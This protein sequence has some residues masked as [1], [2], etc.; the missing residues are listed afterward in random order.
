[1]NKVFK[2][3]SRTKYCESGSAAV[4]FAFI[5]LLL[6]A[7]TVG[8]VEFGRAFWLYNKLSNAIEKTSRKNLVKSIDDAQIAKEIKKDFPT[9]EVGTVW[10]EPP[11]V[12]VTLGPNF[13]TVKAVIA[14][15]PVIPVLMGE[16]IDITLTRRFWKVP[17]AT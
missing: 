2:S 16:N 4:E 5:G 7:G 15:K 12:T 1:M 17:S 8:I 11:E 3:L 6:I 13:R 14:F 10:A 9:A